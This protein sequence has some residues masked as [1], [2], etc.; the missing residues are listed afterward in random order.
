M[1]AEARAVLAATVRGLL[2]LHWLLERALLA[3]HTTREM[4]HA[5]LSVEA[6]SSAL[7]SAH[8]VTRAL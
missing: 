3:N 5:S 4:T 8:D 1:D 6:A 7:A 2:R